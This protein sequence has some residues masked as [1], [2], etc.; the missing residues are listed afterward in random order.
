MNLHGSGP[1]G[2]REAGEVPSVRLLHPSSI[3]AFGLAA[4]LVGSAVFGQSP[5]AVG[6]ARH[7][8][9][10]AQ[11][12]DVA[13]RSR[14]DAAAREDSR[15]S[16][17]ESRWVNRLL[18]EDSPY[19]LQ[20]AGDPVDW[21][22][23]GPE[24]FARARELDRP[25][26]LS[27]GY[28][29]C[30]WC[31]VMGRESFADPDVAALL[32]SA[33]VPVKV[34]RERRPDVDDVAI[35]SLILLNR[36]SAGW[37]T[38][39]VLDTEGRAFAGATYLPRETL[40]E[41]LR[42][43]ETAWRE[44]RADVLVVSEDV[45]DRVERI[46]RAEAASDAL[47]AVEVD[48]ATNALLARA[49]PDHG[50]FAGGPK[51]PHEPD[52]LFLLDRGLRDGDDRSFAFVVDTLRAMS[53]GG[54][55]D[56]VGG[57]FHRYTVDGAWKV[58]HFEKMLANQALTGL[59]LV[60]VLSWRS[61]AELER[62]ARR[63]LDALL[64]DFGLPGGGFA[65]AIDAEDA[66]GEGAFYRWTPEQ[67][68]TALEGTTDAGGADEVV[69]AL[70]IGHESCGDGGSVPCLGSRFR[71]RVER[72][73]T[74]A[75]DLLRR[76]DPVLERLRSSRELRPTPAVDT[77]ILTA[78]NAMA[79]RALVR[80]A[81]VLD[82]PRF[83]RAAEAAGEH[84]WTVARSEGR[85]WLRVVFDG[86]A[87]VAPMLE[88]LAFATDAFLTLARETEPAP[89]GNPADHEL[90]L[91]RAR[92][93]ADA[94][95]ERF[96]RDDGSL[97]AALPRP[98]ESLA[99]TPGGLR[100]GATPAPVAKAIAVLADLGRRTGDSAWTSAARNA[101]AAVAGSA[102]R[103]PASF[104]TLLR[105]VRLLDEGEVGPH[106][107]GAEGR[108]RVRAVLDPGSGGLNWLR[109]RVAIED[110]WHVTSNRP[111]VEGL[112]P[113]ELEIGSARG[114]TLGPIDWPAGDRWEV[115]WAEEPVG[116]FTGA[117]EVR[118]P[119]RLYPGNGPVLGVRLRIQACDDSRCLKPETLRLEV[120]VG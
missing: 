46:L 48:G 27:V 69:E 82:E 114:A 70:G 65:T 98:G 86:R 74:S 20:H 4:A 97:R 102:E 118:A 11:V 6:D 60:E 16:T 54:L 72:S 87:S 15:A 68:V 105:A 1:S 94:M 41:M 80:G 43:V 66:G 45:A 112:L 31:H 24:A 13:L 37:P 84:L 56:Q 44:K 116:V 61:D 36:G 32:N 14:L 19:L 30:H 110:G 99:A 58:P 107:I 75:A 52:L 85:G 100:D 73:G 95:L 17:R 53:R 18:L 119:V 79:V 47:G 26:F 104:P 23:W 91:E 8:L 10:G 93:T 55:H 59:L 28:S 42:R 34:D 51:F 9:P 2:P 63:T 90:W 38:T 103:D 62:A 57:G 67:V 50:G 49:D 78:W 33:F 115:P 101:L 21:F 39:L 109:L 89:K 106:E 77:K 64:R 12:R 3:F 113:A 117:F 83:R 25:L 81:R 76:L 92:Q 7:R 120:P 29:T 22:P 71:E 96:A 111:D 108:V 40:V 5:T 35:T 88:D